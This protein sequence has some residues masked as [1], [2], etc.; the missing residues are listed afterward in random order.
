MQGH[1]AAN[2]VPV[3]AANRFGLEKV[4]PCQEN[5]G[6]SSSLE[7]YG[8]SF[9]A[10]ETGEILCQ[11]GR[12]EEKVLCARFDFEKIRKERMEW[13]LFRDRRPECYREI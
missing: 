8:S 7:F 13:G 6:Q 2:I 12:S 4:E 10:D 11:A 1:A 3:A 5:A 9:I